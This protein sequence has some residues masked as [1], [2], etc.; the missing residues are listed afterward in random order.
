MSA[1]TLDQSLPL[2]RMGLTALVWAVIGTLT[3]LIVAGLAL[4]LHAPIGAMYW[5]SFLY[6][7]AAN[8]IGQG[9][10][11]N[12]DFFTPVGPLEYYLSTWTLNLFSNAQ[13]M[14]AASWS[15]AFVTIPLMA[16]VLSDIARRAPL[17]AL[18]VAVPFALYTL[19]PFNTTEYYNFPGSDGFGIYNRHASQLV[20]VLAAALLFVRRQW[21]LAALIAALM[22]ALFLVKVTGF[23]VAGL[24]CVV[25]LAAGRV[26]LLS[27]IASAVVFAATLAGLEL[28]NGMISA[29]LADI[30]ALFQ[31]NDT[32]M[33]HRL[34]QGAS[35]TGGTVIFAG[36]TC[37]VLLFAMPVRA[38]P[39]QPRWK[40]A[41]DHPVIWIGAAV[42]GGIFFESQNT[43]SQEMIALWPVIVHALARMLS[44]PGAHAAKAGVALLAGCT[45]LPPLV[46]TIQHAAR[47]NLAMVRQ[48]APDHA[49]WGRAG[50][51]TVRPRMLERFER[52]RAHY[53]AWPEATRALADRR[54]LPAYVLYSEHDFQVG[55]MHDADEVAGELAR[56]EAEGL[57]YRT[58]MTL[59]FANPFAFMLDKSAP[60]HIAIG[61][62]PYRAVPEPDAAVYEAVADTDI[63]LEPHCPYRDNSRELHAIYAPALTGHVKVTLTDCYAAYVRPAIAAQLTR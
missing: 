22:L 34:V 36:L 26:H 6:L 29:Y 43:G 60:R 31:I 50:R 54:E 8:R 58:I 53:I 38:L 5:D 27:A 15:I 23:V 42:A 4:P 37:L 20:Y 59:D 10:V 61:A 14:Y 16:L 39:D 13:P 24:L 62:D 44:E 32:S 2:P 40:A 1:T 49:N 48:I 19:L 47:A 9:Q 55:L 33:A 21:L 51:I 18:A 52:M 12:V 56:L 7:D 25:A 30:A 35:R 63:V 17:V 57:S 45:V 11:P 3:A 46:Q 28:A 41:F